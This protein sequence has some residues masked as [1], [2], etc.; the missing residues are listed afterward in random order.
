MASL[1]ESL[2]QSLTPDLVGQIGKSV[3]L[4]NSLVNKGLGVVG[5]LVTGAL[6]N[7]AQSPL[8]IDGL[9]KLMPQ[10]TGSS[11]IGSLVSMLTGGGA[12]SSLLSGLF[13]PGLS[14]ITGTLDRSLGFK[15]AP[16][17]GMA[18]PLVMNL[19]GQTMK[20]RNLDKAGV[21]QLLQDEH[22]QLMNSGSET[23]K[24]VMKALDAGKEAAVTKARYSADQWEKVRIAPMVVAQ[25]VMDASPSGVL[26]RSKELAAVAP[27][28]TSFRNTASPTSLVSLAFDAD[29]TD[30]ETDAVKEKPAAIGVIREA[31]AAVSTNSPGD[32]SE[33]G[34][35]LVN[36]ATQVA[37]ASKEGGF[38]GVGGTRVSE[39]EQK[40]IDEI[41]ALVGI[42]A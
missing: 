20:S 39:T 36:V 1:I 40:A 10:A 27:A 31:V 21:A 28:I 25:A 14:A 41:R 11:G 23:S 16:L 7:T 26:G 18:A 6:A 5:P 2:T 24:L 9:M 35:L 34:R 33:Y 32:A 29:L 12:S 8:G 19:V 15:V 30:N 4:D 42:A 38:L 17:I 13:G 3:G 22:K 37:E